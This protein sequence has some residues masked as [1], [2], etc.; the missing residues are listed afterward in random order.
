MESLADRFGV[1]LETED[2]DPGAAARRQ[3]RERLH[4]LLDRVDHLLLAL[5]VGGGRGAG[6]A[7]LPAG[8]RPDRGDAQGVPG[9]LRAQRLGPD[10][11]APR[12]RA[13]YTDEELLAAGLAQRS[14]NRPGSVYDRFRERIMF[15]AVDARG[16]VHGFGAR[17]D[18]REPGRRRSTSTPPTASSTTSARS[19]SGSTWRA[20]PP[21]RPGR[22]ILV[23]GYTD[24]LA[25]HQAGIRNAVGIM[26][27]SLTEEQVR[28]LERVVQ[29]AGAVPRR[30][31]GRPGGDAA[32]LAPGRRARPGAARGPAA[33]G[34]RPRRPDR[35]RRGRGAA[36][37]G[38]RARR[39]SSSSTSS[40][41]S[42][43][44]TPRSAEGRDR[45]LAELRPVL[46]ELPRQRPARRAGAPGR[47]APG[48]DR[49]PAG[50]AAG[51]GGSA[52]GLAPASRPAGQ[53]AGPRRRA[54]G[55][56]GGRRA[57]PGGARRAPLPGAVPG[58]ARRRAPRLLAR[59]RRRRAAHQ[60]GAAPRRAPPGRALARAAGRPARRRRGVRPHR[61]AAWSSSPA[62][63]RTPAPTAW[64]TPASSSSSTAWSAR[65]S[66]PGPTGAGTSDLAHRARGGARRDAGRRWRGSRRPSELARGGVDERGVMSRVS[67]RL[68]RFSVRPTC[69]HMF[70]VDR[71]ARETGWI[72]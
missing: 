68:Q 1:Q 42:S 32:R 4:S 48:A 36:H 24:V 41:S 60:H 27:T 21:P 43:A 22:M 58:G 50:H 51:S 9:R 57:G 17:R 28:E 47:R 45:A 38:A 52:G 66:A 33:R 54:G 18:A 29:G 35:A 19:C 69:E 53:R 34:H 56:R 55:G 12:G 67:T 31:P 64:S 44:P 70:L 2:E 16:R 61:S 14:R 40:G 15:P 3:R 39:R 5:P 71:M 30:R 46:N 8:A 49:G 20:R 72:E 63:S 11:A 62:A 65:S 7:R 6:R 37:A 23:E 59:D 26:G 10:A 13:G 25:L